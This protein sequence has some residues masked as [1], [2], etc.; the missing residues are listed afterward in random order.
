MVLATSESV[1][2]DIEKFYPDKNS[3]VVSLP[4]SPIFDPKFLATKDDIENVKQKY[5]LPAKYFM[6]SNQ[7]WIHKSHSTAFEALHILIK[8]KRLKDIHIVCTGKMIDYRFRNYIE[9]L[10]K[11]IDKLEISSNV[12]FLGYIPKSDQ[13][14]IMQNSI[15]IIQPTLFEGAPGGLAVHDA[16]GMGVRSIV[17]DIPINKEIE[18]DLVTFFEVKNSKDLADKMELLY[19]EPF[20]KLSKEML[21]QKSNE[22]LLQLNQKLEYAINLALKK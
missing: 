10:K 15:A 2:N 5:N 4:F 21:K 14:F 12:H 7:F 6:I 9:D 8:E 16:V 13:L 1:K 18:D 17:S 22:R 20:T 11:L 3:I 19:N